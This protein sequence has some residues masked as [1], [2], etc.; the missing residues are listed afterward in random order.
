MKKMYANGI[1][2]TYVL[3]IY[4]LLYPLNLVRKAEER[5]SSLRHTL[6][7]NNWKCAL[8]YPQNIFMSSP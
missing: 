4:D 7:G 1:S 6:R 3:Y 5:L 8:V 2:E